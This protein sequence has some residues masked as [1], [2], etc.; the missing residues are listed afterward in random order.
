MWRQPDFLKA[1]ASP[2]ERK[3]RSPVMRA[4][5]KP[6]PL[7]G[8]EATASLKARRALARAAVTGPEKVRTSMSRGSI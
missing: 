2:A 7:K 1:S 3:E 6:E 5:R 4:V 8:M